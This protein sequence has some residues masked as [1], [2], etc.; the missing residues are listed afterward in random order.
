MP[1]AVAASLLI[2]FIACP[3]LIAVCRRNGWYDEVDPRKI[4]EGQVPRLG[5]VAVVSAFLAGSAV[6]LVRTGA[7][8]IARHGPVLAGLLVVFIMGVADD[9][10][11]LRARLKLFV[12]IAAA[13]CAVCGP[14][15]FDELFG[16]K[17]PLAPVT[18][19]LATFGWIVLVV[20]AYNLIDGMDWVCGGLSTLGL[21]AYGAMF[22]LK[23][24]GTGALALVMCAS[25]AGFMYWNRPKARIFL[26]DGGSL[27]IGYALAVFPLLPQGDEMF[28]FNRVI[29]AFMVASIPVI[30]VFAAILRRKREHRSFFSP[31]RRHL[32]HKLMNIGF[33]P[34]VIRLLLF[35]LQALISTVVVMT[36]FVGRKTG[37]ALLLSAMAFTSIF[38]VSIHY[39][40]LLITKKTGG[41]LE[42]HPQQ[43]H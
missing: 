23:G 30:D 20:N 34:P 2:S 38:F 6:L 40:N 36:S 24:D 31:D 8:D 10:L 17:F 16:L 13:A 43:E 3:A 35:T 28:R 4:H 26:G 9:F 27:S 18:G 42:D 5:G 15:Y 25:I 11:N 29:I 12:Q 21:A 32:H 1:I 22:L 37:A 7:F 19:R 33:K 39:I 14:C 41:H